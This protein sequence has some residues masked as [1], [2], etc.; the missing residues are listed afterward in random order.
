MVSITTVPVHSICNINREAS[1]LI[2]MR[3]RKMVPSI[4]E[5]LALAIGIGRVITWSKHVGSSASSANVF[6]IHE[7][8]YSNLVESKSLPMFQN[9][10][11][12]EF[13]QSADL[14]NTHGVSLVVID[15]SPTMSSL[16]SIQWHVGVGVT[17]VPEL[18]CT[19]SSGETKSIVVLRIREVVLS[20]RQLRALAITV[21]PM[22]TRSFQ[23]VILAS[24]Q[25]VGVG[26]LKWN[27]DLVESVT[28]VV[29]D[30]N[31]W[32]SPLS[33]VRLHAHDISVGP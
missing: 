11:R 22:I 32:N 3:M 23:V 33:V 25:N 26:H 27:L 21:C 16:E 13:R 18:V 31:G 14:V 7:S 19:L 6:T 1:D 2:V 10:N 28:S 4:G 24:G 20:N 12:L 30:G 8:K 29:L 15:I 17:S 5:L 9:F